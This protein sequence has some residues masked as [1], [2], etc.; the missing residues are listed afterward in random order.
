MDE[1]GV[2]SMTQ[3]RKTI[4]GEGE[5]V[6]G[7]G[8]RRPWLEVGV[9]I[10]IPAAFPGLKYVGLGPLWGSHSPLPHDLTDKKE[11]TH[12]RPQG[13]KWLFLPLPNLPFG[14]RPGASSLPRRGCGPLPVPP[15]RLSQDR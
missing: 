8:P 6:S 11:E 3:D 15:Q 7:R 14:V 13:G 12:P 1:V 9:G 10:Q 5:Q 4:I 2:E